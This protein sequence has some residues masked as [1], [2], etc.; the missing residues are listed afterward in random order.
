M[1]RLRVLPLAM[2]ALVR[3][4]ASSK[5]TGRVDVRFAARPHICA[6]RSTS[7]CELFYIRLDDGRARPCTLQK[8]VSSSVPHCVAGAA[9]LCAALP[10]RA[11]SEMKSVEELRLALLRRRRMRRRAFEARLGA[12]CKSVATGDGSHEDCEGW[13]LKGGNNASSTT[14]ESCKYC[15]CRACRACYTRPLPT[16]ATSTLKG[17]R[18][19]CELFGQSICNATGNLSAMIKS[20]EAAAYAKWQFNHTNQWI[21][22]IFATTYARE[23][24]AYKALGASLP[25]MVPA[26]TG[27][28]EDEV[29]ELRQ[30]EPKGGGARRTLSQSV[31]SAAYTKQIVSDHTETKWVETIF[32]TA[33]RLERAAYAAIAPSLPKMVPAEHGLTQSEI[34]AMA[35]EA[36]GAAAPEIFSG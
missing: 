13:C 1:P 15:K 33:Y 23:G 30:A 6:A 21:D 29:A 3:C 14:P 36:A 11:V 8:Q 10:S 22:H 7:T 20:V 28:A 26:E 35:A 25:R 18:A 12:R 19:S 17:M 16:W 27:L 4:S 31:E 5:C 32:A 24:A 34:A 2:L 9:D